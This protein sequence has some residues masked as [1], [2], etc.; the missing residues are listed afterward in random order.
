MKR[1]PDP[2][3]IELDESDCQ[4]QIGF[5]DLHASDLE[6][7]HLLYPLVNEHIAPITEAF[8]EKLLE[9]PHLRQLVTTHSSIDALKQTLKQHILEMFE[10]KVDAAFLLSVNGSHKPMFELALKPSG[11][12]A[13]F[14][15]CN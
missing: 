3:K 14:T 8:Y 7:I 10:G 15:T 12:S 11:T 4:K 13:L 2:I 6:Y 9:Q 1:E 5:I